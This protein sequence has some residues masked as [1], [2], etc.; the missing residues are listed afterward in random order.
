MKKICEYCGK[1]MEVR[2]SKTRFC[3]KSCIASYRNKLPENRLKSAEICRERNKT[4]AMRE[5]ASLN[6]KRLRP[7]W[8]RDPA[9]LE[10]CR[11]SRR[12]SMI[13]VNKSQGMNKPKD[14]ENY[15]AS[16]LERLGIPYEREFR[17]ELESTRDEL[18]RFSGTYYR[19][20]FYIPSF[21]MDLEIDGSI[22]EQESQ[23]NHDT[24][25]D[26]VLRDKGFSVVRV[27]F[28][29]DYNSLER[30]ILSIFSKVGVS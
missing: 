22:H 2:R 24:L 20:D 30:E 21:S 28:R 29:G 1:E 23:K 17:V 8:D 25:R 26:A 4:P 9:I 27:P 12:N 19:L 15:V 5:A 6:M 11:D 7:E 10:K 18:G 14:S 3:S 13:Q 16:I